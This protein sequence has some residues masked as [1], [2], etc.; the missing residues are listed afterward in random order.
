M[1]SSSQVKAIDYTP[2]YLVENGAKDLP[3]L[4]TQNH[5]KSIVYTEAE[6]K[7]KGLRYCE[8]INYHGLGKELLIKAIDNMDSPSAVYRQ[9]GNN[10]LIITELTDDFGNDIIMPVKINGRGM[11]N[12]V[13]IDENHITS[14]YGKKIFKIILRRIIL[15][16]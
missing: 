1:H 11:Y 13:Y 7:E 16:K 14:V 8:N 10:F 3:M 6:A 2:K 15:K 9:S 5:L 4:I 12:N